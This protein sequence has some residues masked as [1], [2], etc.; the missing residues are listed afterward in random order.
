[1]HAA[2][3][4]LTA[5]FVLLT[6]LSLGAQAAEQAIDITP[7][8]VSNIAK[9]YGSAVLQK[10]SK[11]QPIVFG[12]INGQA[13]AIIFVGCE[14]DSCSMFE[15]VASLDASG[16]GLDKINAWNSKNRFGK[17]NLNKDKIFFSQ[18]VVSRYGLPR[19]TLERYFG[20]W[21]LVLGK[22]EPFLKGQ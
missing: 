17:A 5:A 3:S 21:E 19:Q 7:D 16:I 14:S 6:G 10:D 12:R 15:F 8:L 13:Y 18:P 20:F 22:A 9:G 1:M 2:I 11:G 4:R